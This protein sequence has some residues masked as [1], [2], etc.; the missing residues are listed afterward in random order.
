M[1]ETLLCTILL[2]TFALSCI[3]VAGLLRNKTHLQRVVREAARETVVANDVSA[4]KTRGQYIARLY[5]YKTYDLV[6]LS[7][8]LREKT[9]G[10]TKVHY[11][12][13]KATYPYKSEIL[14]REVE[15]NAQATF[16]WI[17]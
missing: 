6:Q 9:Q 4:G 5:D 11:A 12:E 15:L 3:E 16:G 10:T 17:E 7:I 8:G 13:A 1:L 14:G 2:I